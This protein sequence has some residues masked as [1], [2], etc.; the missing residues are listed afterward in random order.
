[1]WLVASLI[2]HFVTVGLGSVNSLVVG[3]VL[4]VVAGKT[5]LLREVGSSRTTDGESTAA[6]ENTPAPA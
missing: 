4:Y 5:G 6:V 2:G 1:M 3:F